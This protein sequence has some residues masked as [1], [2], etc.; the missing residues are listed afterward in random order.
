MTFQ[1]SITEAHLVFIP[2]NIPKQE[3]KLMNEIKHQNILKNRI[4]IINT[5][6]KVMSRRY[7]SFMVCH[8]PILK[9]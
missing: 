8:F 7:M 3:N 1:K 9:K 5:N 4:K 6:K 2:S